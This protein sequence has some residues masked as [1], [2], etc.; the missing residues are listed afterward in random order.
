MKLLS[1]WYAR[2]EELEKVG[3][4][5]QK[6]CPH[7]IIEVMDYLGRG[8]RIRCTNCGKLDFSSYDSLF[9]LYA[10]LGDKMLVNARRDEG[11]I[12][13]EDYRYS[14]SISGCDKCDRVTVG[15]YHKK[16]EEEKTEENKAIESAKKMFKKTKAKV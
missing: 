9:P 5:L 12:V 4:A 7:E 16:T 15:V 13:L 3:L 11:H 6:L 1:R 2:K 14:H 10:T 8:K